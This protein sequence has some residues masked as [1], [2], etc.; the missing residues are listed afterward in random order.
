MRFDVVLQSHASRKPSQTAVIMEDGSLTYREL[1][2]GAEHIK[3]ALIAYG[4]KPGDRVALYLPNSLAYLQAFF[5]ILRAGAIVVP[6]STWLTPTEMSFCYADSGAKVLIIGEAQHR[7]SDAVIGKIIGK[8]VVVGGSAKSSGEALFSEMLA[9]PIVGLPEIPISQ[10]D[11]LILYTSGTTGAPKG[12][13]LTHE[14]MVVT[15]LVNGLDWK[16]YPHDRFLVATP[17]ANRTGTAR[18]INSIVLGATL[19]VMR[20]FDAEN[21]LSFVE[22]ENVT[23]V[24]SVPTMWKRLMPFLE[25]GGRCPSLKTILVTGEKF[26]VELNRRVR[27]ALPGV[28]IVS[29]F[30]MTETGAVTSLEGEDQINFP[31][32]IGRPTA[33]VEVKIVDDAFCRVTAGEVGEMLIRAGRPGSM[34]IMREYFK[35]PEINAEAFR[36]GWFRTGDLCRQ[37]ANGYIYLVDRKKDMI[38]SGGINIYSKEVENAI[39]EHDAVA[40]SAV[41]A[42]PDSEFGEA[43]AAFVQLKPNEKISADEI[44]EHCRTRIGKYKKPKYVFLVSDFPRNSIGKILKRELAERGKSMLPEGRLSRAT[45]N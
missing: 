15:G 38:I 9:T 27:S 44:I 28:R 2:E 8:I 40:D 3:S 10:E 12:V 36:D 14:N 13:V 42:I 34:L 1:Y 20:S 21:W 45:S 32:S 18:I 29:F 6:F 39:N 31:D 24:G 17:L 43:V 23:V 41:V 25:R 19:C 30:G 16:I 11:C 37:D 7:Q 22:R 35:K 26:P 5:G 33:G 4:I